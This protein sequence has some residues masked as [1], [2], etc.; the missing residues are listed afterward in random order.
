MKEMRGSKDELHRVCSFYIL[1][2]INGLNKSMIRPII[3]NAIFLLDYNLVKG[4]TIHL[5]H[6][7]ASTLYLMRNGKWTII[8]ACEE[9]T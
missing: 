5:L 2:V 7:V 4:L 1:Y 8:N 9:P 6:W 3:N